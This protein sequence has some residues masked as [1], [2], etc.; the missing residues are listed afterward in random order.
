MTDAAGRESFTR[1]RRAYAWASVVVIALF[2]VVAALLTSQWW[3]LALLLSLAL[4]MIPVGSFRR[5]AR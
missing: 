5:S 4:P 3:P 1:R 2:G